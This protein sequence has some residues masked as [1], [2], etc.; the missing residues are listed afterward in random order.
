MMVVANVDALDVS[1]HDECMRA[2]WY[3]LYVYSS[4]LKQQKDERNGWMDGWMDCRLIN[5]ER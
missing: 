5:W 1:H 2:F 3:S 4:F